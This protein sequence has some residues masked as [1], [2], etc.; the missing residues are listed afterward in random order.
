MRTKRL[1]K[2]WRHATIWKFRNDII[3]NNSNKVMEEMVEEI[4]VLS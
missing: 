3:F 4:K 2:G 1:R